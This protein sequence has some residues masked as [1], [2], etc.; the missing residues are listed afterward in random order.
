MQFEYE[1]KNVFEW[2]SGNSS[3][4]WAKRAKSVISIEDDAKWFEK[5]KSEKR[6]NIKIYLFRWA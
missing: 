3:F 2:G 6:K 4:F 1:D 5:V